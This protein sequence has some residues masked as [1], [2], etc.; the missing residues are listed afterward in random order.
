MK[1]ATDASKQKVSAEF[2]RRVLSTTNKFDLKFKL[3]GHL[4]AVQSEREIGRL[5]T[6][7]PGQRAEFDF[8]KNGIFLFPNAKW[9]EPVLYVDG[10]GIDHASGAIGSMVTTMTSTSRDVVR[11]FRRYV[12]PKSTWLP[13]SSHDIAQ[14]WDVFGIPSLTA[15][16][17]GSDF[18]SN[19][20]FAM[21]IF[22][23]SI[24]LK[25][26]PSR[27]DLK[28]GVERSQGTT[29]T[30]DISHLSGYISKEHIGLNP[31]YNKLRERAKAAASM[32]LEEYQAIRAVHAVEHNHGLHPRLRKRRIDVFRDGQEQAPLLL[33][34]NSIQ[35]RLTFALTYFVKL[36]REGVEIET[37]KFNSPELHEAYLIYTGSVCVKMDPDDVRAVLVLIPNLSE[38][39]EARLTSF[40]HSHPVTFELYQHIR[41]IHTAEANAAGLQPEVIPFSFVEKLESVQG[42]TQANPD[43]TVTHK[44]IQAAS[45]AAAM[46]IA[47]PPVLIADDLAALLA[48]TKL[49]DE[50]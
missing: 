45:H 49:S 20:A 25:L 21:F 30:R 15:I 9:K 22:T 32:T 7:Y 34:T 6:W 14:Q 16:D 31:K 28:G 42:A 5:H 40:S 12:M 39:I 19:N 11:L 13:L 41:S 50:R 46:P 36:T 8:T 17:N 44:Q 27:G 26:P 10:M 37:L 1:K 29:E 2:I 23:G 33:L 43:W 38:P 48:G 35:H 47:Q 18:I 4:F 3:L 24:P